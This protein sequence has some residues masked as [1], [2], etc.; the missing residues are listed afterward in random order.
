MTKK[1]YS[2]LLKDP[3]W[4]KK[5]LEIFNRDNWKCKLCGDNKTTL[6]VHH[7]EYLNGNDPWDYPKDMLVTICEH[8]HSEISLDQYKGIPYDEITIHKS[9][10]WENGSRIMFVQHKRECSMRTYA[11]DGKFVSGFNIPDFEAT[12]IIKILKRTQ[13]L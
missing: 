13:R 1:S 11:Q 6:Q 10:N 4:Q 2:E 7:K 12:G 5:R 9:A 8:C 3:R